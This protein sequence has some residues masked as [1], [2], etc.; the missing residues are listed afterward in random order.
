MILSDFIKILEPFSSPDALH[1]FFPTCFCTAFFGYMC[2]PNLVQLMIFFPHL[3][4]FIKALQYAKSTNR[5]FEL[6]LMLPPIDWKYLIKSY[7]CV[8]R[9]VFRFYFDRK[10]LLTWCKI[11]CWGQGDQRCVVLV[12]YAWRPRFSSQ[13]VWTPKHLRKEPLS[14][15]KCCQE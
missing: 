1:I 14:S 10:L 11:I 3:V 8:L 13:H 5:E 9:I 15:S 12:L 6:I 7:I 2:I 4:F